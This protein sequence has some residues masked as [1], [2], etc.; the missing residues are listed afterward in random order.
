MAE[1]VDAFWNN[2]VEP[3][4]HDTANFVSIG[5]LIL[6]Y[7]IVLMQFKLGTPDAITGLN[8]TLSDLPIYLQNNTIEDFK[9]LM[10]NATA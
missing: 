8:M 1:V 4:W 9:N 7:L 3:P 2:S 6:T 10:S 5:G